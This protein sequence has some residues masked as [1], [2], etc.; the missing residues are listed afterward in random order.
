MNDKARIRDISS[1]AAD[2]AEY[3]SITHASMKAQTELDDLKK[4][5]KSAKTKFKKDCLKRQEKLT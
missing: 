1:A 5:L 4:V 2:Q 3:A